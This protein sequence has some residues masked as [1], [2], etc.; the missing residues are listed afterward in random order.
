MENDPAHFDAALSERLTEYL[1]TATT[2]AY[3]AGV[4]LLN[5][6]AFTTFQEVSRFIRDT[7][8]EAR[9]FAIKGLAGSVVASLGSCLGQTCRDRPG[10]TR[11]GVALAAVHPDHSGVTSSRAQ[12]RLRLR[13]R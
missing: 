9:K 10:R 1:N 8:S 12:D 7:G 4:A 13:S 3:L 5:D 2:E 11:V 6:I